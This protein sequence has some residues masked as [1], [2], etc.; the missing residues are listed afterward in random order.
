MNIDANILKKIQQKE[1]NKTLK[2]SYIKIKW[3]LSQG[4]K[5]SSIYA[6]QPMR[7]IILTY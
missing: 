5:D 6:N 4:C 7:Y 2:G 1:S 3:A